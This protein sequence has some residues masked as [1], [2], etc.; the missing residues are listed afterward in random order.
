MFALSVVQK[1]TELL[2]V[3]DFDLNV[4]STIPQTFRFWKTIL[5]LFMWNVVALVLVHYQAQPWRNCTTIRPNSIG[6]FVPQ[7]TIFY[8]PYEEKPPSLNT[9][10]MYMYLVQVT[11]TCATHC[12]HFSI[13]LSLQRVLQLVA[14]SSSALEPLP[15]N[16]TA[17]VGADYDR[18]YLLAH[19]KHILECK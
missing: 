18:M 7:T 2:P 11:F 19:S 3:K 6:L 13:L 17:L 16:R 12:M 10:Y 9:R 14:F 15:E 5:F 4:L 8:L 1:E